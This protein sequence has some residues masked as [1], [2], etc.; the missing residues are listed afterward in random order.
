MASELRARRYPGRDRLKCGNRT[1]NPVA[2]SAPRAGNATQSACDDDR[3]PLDARRPEH[4]PSLARQQ[5]RSMLRL[6]VK[7]SLWPKSEH[8]SGMPIGCRA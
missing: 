2:V 1:G 6:P 7:R 8:S 5:K 4:A 3:P